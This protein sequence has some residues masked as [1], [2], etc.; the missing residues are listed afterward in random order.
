VFLSGV[1]NALEVDRRLHAE[2]VPA[3]PGEQTLLARRLGYETHPRQSFLNDYLRIT[4]RSRR[5]M[6]RVF[7][8]AL[9]QPSGGARPEREPGAES[10]GAPC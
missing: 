5:A 7:A 10:P 9:D 6:T 1:K 4:R 3:S 2:A 8:E